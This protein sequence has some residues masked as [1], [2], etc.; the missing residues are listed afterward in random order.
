S[1][2][3]PVVILEKLFQPFMLETLDHG[4]STS[5]NHVKQCFT[6]VKYNCT[7]TFMYLFLNHHTCGEAISAK[8]REGISRGCEDPLA[9]IALLEAGWSA[10][11]N[12]CLLKSGAQ[13]QVVR[14][15]RRPKSSRP[16]NGAGINQIE[17]D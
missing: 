4:P 16:N 15:V 13:W 2:P 12:K 11:Q 8:Q 6:C 14:L 10:P 5:S 3:F 17:I 7:P 9:I 1:H